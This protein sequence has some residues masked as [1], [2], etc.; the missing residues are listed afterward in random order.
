MIDVNFVSGVITLQTEDEV[1]L[2][3]PASKLNME[4]LCRRHGIACTMSEQHCEPLKAD[5]DAPEASNDEPEEA[6]DDAE[7][8]VI[9][10]EQPDEE[11]TVAIARSKAERDA[12]PT[13]NESPKQPNG[14]ARSNRSRRSGRWRGRRQGG[15]S[16]GGSQNGGSQNGGAQ[17]SGGEH[18]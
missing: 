10:A 8:D 3:M 16:N 14:E 18:K 13:Q 17:N 6:E 12:S 4:G 5:P 9:E 2:H 1:Q 15:P 11:G 7:P